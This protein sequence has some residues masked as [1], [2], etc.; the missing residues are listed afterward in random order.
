M[1]KTVE[2]ILE[3]SGEVRL[4]EPVHVSR[5]SRV[6]L[7][8]LKIR[9]GNIYKVPFSFTGLTQVKAR[10]ALGHEILE[11]SASKIA[12]FPGGSL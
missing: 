2:A 7:T 3:P 4:L 5:P 8:L 10:P 11:F 1:L 9:V 6:L 12:G